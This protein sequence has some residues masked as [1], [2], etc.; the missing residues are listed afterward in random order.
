M[1]KSDFSVEI[2]PFWAVEA[3]A[4]AQLNFDRGV[5]L[6]KRT[7]TDRSPELIWALTKKN[8]QYRRKWMGK[9]WSVSPWSMDGRWNAKNEGNTIG[10]EVRKDSTDKNFKRTFTMSLKSSH[11]NGISKNKKNSQ[12]SPA[13]SSM[14]I[15]RSPARAAKAVNAQR[16]VTPA[17][18]KAALRKLAALARSTN[19]NGQGKE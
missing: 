5:Y 17:Q 3:L 10:V 19:G 9:D 2:E 11:K 7:M 4:R 14:D 6:G 13:W 16:P 12:S 15:G 8:S 18:K 1:N